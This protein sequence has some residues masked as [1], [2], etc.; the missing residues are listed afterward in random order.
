MTVCACVYV[1][2][3]V[4]CST[5]QVSLRLLLEIL[6]PMAS[7]LV[8]CNQQDFSSLSFCFM[9]VKPGYEGVFICWISARHLNSHRWISP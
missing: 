4:L 2:V 9:H 6:D 1:R 8:C 3:Y 5:L 7:M